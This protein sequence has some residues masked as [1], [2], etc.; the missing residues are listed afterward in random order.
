[1]MMG[2]ARV[3]DAKEVPG[4]HWSMRTRFDR[5]KVHSSV[6]GS[7]PTPTPIEVKPADF[8]FVEN[9]RFS[10]ATPY[11]SCICYV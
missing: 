1:M 5:A 7:K 8:F 2:A 3:A 11:R 6:G 4:D 10:T 9:V